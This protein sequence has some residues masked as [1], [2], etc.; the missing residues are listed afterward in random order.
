MRAADRKTRF[1]LASLLAASVLAL[2]I[3][4]P[5]PSQ[6]KVFEPESFTL[7]NGLQVVV[8]TNRRAPIVT[9][10]V[11][12]KVGAADEA[13]GESGLAHFLEHLMFKGTEV[14]GPGE[15]SEIIAANGG[16]E[17]AFTGS[18]YTGYYQTVARD[19]L[20]IV[21]KHE[22]D[23]M[24]NLRLTD[25]LVDPERQVVLEERRSRIGNEPGSQLWEMIGAA[26]FLNHPYRRPVIGWEHEIKEL[27]TEGALAF[28]RRWYAPNNAI[29][30]VAGDVDA[31]EVRPLAEKYY[32]AIPRGEVPERRRVEEPPHHA[33]RSVTL[34][35][36]RVRQPSFSI[37]YL[38]PSYTADDKGHAY[39]LQVLDDIMGGGATSRLYRALVVEQ[40][41]A[42]SA[43]I[44]LRRRQ[45]WTSPPSCSAPRRGSGSRW[46]RSRPRCAPRSPGSWPRASAR[47]RSPLRSAGS[48]PWRSMPAT[49]LSTGARVIGAA[50]T[51]GQTIEDVEAWPE[52]IDAVTAA[53]VNEAAKALV[54]DTHSVT[55]VSAAEAD[56]LNRPT[57]RIASHDPARNFDR[58]RLDT[59]RQFAGTRRRG[60]AGRQ[61]GRHRGLAGRGP[62]QPDHLARPGLPRRRRARSRRPRG[63]GQPGLRPVRRGRGRAQFPAFQGRLSD[64]SIGL[65]F[66][67][68][69][70]T[71]GGSLRTL[72]ENRDTAFDLL[73]LALNEPRFDAEPVERIRGPD[74][75]PGAPQRRGPGPDRRPHPEAAVLSR[76]S[77]PAAPWRGT[78]QSIAA[79]TADDLKRF[80]AE[81]LA[82]DVLKIAVVGDITAAEL[83]PL[84]D[85]TF[86]ALPAAASPAQVADTEPQNGGEVVVIRKDI[87]QSVVSLGHAGLK[88]DHPDFYTAYVI[89]NIMGGGGFSS[90]LYEEIREKRGLAY[91]VHSYLYPQDHAA[92]LIGGVAT[93][94]ARVGQ[95]LELIRREWARMAES[96]PTAEELDAAKTFLTGSYPLR[97]SS[98]SRISGMLL[99]IQLE[100]LGID[101]I[102]R[103]NAYIEAVTLEDAKRVARKLYRED[104]LTV[105]VVGQ[106]EG[107]EAT[108]AAPDG[109]S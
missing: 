5:G 13:E 94:N 80:V 89:N 33:A 70:D 6:A 69:R 25:E 73:R 67:A 95:S 56:L 86:L 92:M 44:A 78:P 58:R 82:R 103:R 49:A 99:G 38:A 66:D 57:E 91:S 65:S 20:E 10:M 39:A 79:I 63:P 84:L 107:I 102:N 23:R 21:M 12:Y 81:R 85:K 15:F 55:A 19:R 77:L 7:D 60:A 88:R 87:P 64:L 47:P 24:V 14:L 96:G 109:G 61:P 76:A 29:L 48:S 31:D 52:R 45:S 98:S 34:E 36:K 18:D 4:L 17:N 108:R 41:L 22:A 68:G 72:T 43:G 26:M 54:R 9:H 59:L 53:E 93:A 1:A 97:Q 100:D 75:G 90:R 11:Y 35:S 62:Q 37:S 2:L 40:G 30:I 16:V 27:S 3:A 42:A 46:R 28:Y 32:G 71:F 105:V 74:P 106:P 51:T 8:I 104:Q 83:A 50:L 101:Y